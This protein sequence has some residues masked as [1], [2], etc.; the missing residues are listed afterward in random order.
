LPGSKVSFL[1]C[2]TLQTAKLQAS[3]L[4]IK[5]YIHKTPSLLSVSM[6]YYE[7]L[8]PAAFAVVVGRRCRRRRCSCFKYGLSKPVG[9]EVEVW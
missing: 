9:S 3:K 8:L 4:A 2:A 7:S 5:D 1:K 6:S